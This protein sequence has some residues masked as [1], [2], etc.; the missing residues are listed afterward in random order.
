MLWKYLKFIFIIKH[1]KCTV[2]IKFLI[3][4]NSS[5]NSWQGLSSYKNKNIYQLHIKT[6][7]LTL[8][9]SLEKKCIFEHGAKTKN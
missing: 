1:V 5:G 4:L 8:V 2:Y 3:V 6:G 7:I 9:L